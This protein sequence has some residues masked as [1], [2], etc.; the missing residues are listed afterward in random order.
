MPDATLMIGAGIALA[1]VSSY[2]L[3][4]WR[5]SSMSARAPSQRSPSAWRALSPGAEGQ[6]AWWRAR[7]AFG[8]CRQR[9]TANVDR[10][11]ATP[12]GSPCRFSGLP[13][14]VVGGG[15]EHQRR[16]RRLRRAGLV[17][18]T[19]STSL[20]LARRPHPQRDGGGGAVPVR[21]RWRQCSG[22][23]D[24]VERRGR[25]RAP[26]GRSPAGRGGRRLQ[27][28]WRQLAV[29]IDATF[30]GSRLVDGQLWMVR[31]DVS[32]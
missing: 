32:M 12:R 3:R 14:I 17:A 28:R 10:R 27:A 13:F 15:L 5:R 9:R 20:A 1:A 25:P 11:G 26:C 16:R 19:T 8:D 23:R 30:L 4:R 22:Q 21:P 31:N 24:S 6:C 7:G 18:P 2:L 29:Q